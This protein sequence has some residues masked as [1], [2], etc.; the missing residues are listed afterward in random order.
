MAHHSR[1]R[2]S[3]RPLKAR[4]A[5]S[6]AQAVSQFGTSA[7]LVLLE[8]QRP[9]TFAV[10]TRRPVWLLSGRDSPSTS[11]RGL[12][13]EG[14]DP[15]TAVYTAESLATSPATPNNPMSRA[16]LKQLASNDISARTPDRPRKRN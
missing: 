3:A 9:A 4:V 11:A 8:G 7:S 2:M 6:S 5:S 16:T 12:G 1:L 13:R 10:P 14:A 15:F